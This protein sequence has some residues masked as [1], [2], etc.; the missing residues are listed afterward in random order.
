MLCFKPRKGHCHKIKLT[1]FVF[2][3]V[4][5][6]FWQLRNISSHGLT[7]RLSHKKQ[8]LDDNIDVH[9]I[10]TNV[11]HV[12]K[13]VSSPKGKVMFDGRQNTTVKGRNGISEKLQGQLS[14]AK[15]HVRQAVKR[16][17]SVLLLMWT[18]PWGVS[19]EGP[20]EG[21]TS[22]NCSLTYKREFLEEADAVIF[23]YMTAPR[24]WSLPRW[25]MHYMLHWL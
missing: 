22:G 9:V 6:L 2:V 1:L 14:F 17:S 8:I 21:W 10:K 5:V 11:D 16:E 24:D 3:I 23:P 13:P 20:K 12:K 25:N 15:Q 4:L 7:V 19:S 18:H